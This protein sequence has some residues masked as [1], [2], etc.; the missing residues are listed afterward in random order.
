MIDKT[1]ESKLI[2]SILRLK[3]DKAHAVYLVDGTKINIVRDR[4]NGAWLEIGPVSTYTADS[5]PTPK[6][7]KL[8]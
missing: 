2:R 4:Y 8:K 3:D 7:G 5:H 1:H 6:G